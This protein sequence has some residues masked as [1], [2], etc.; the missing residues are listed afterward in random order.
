MLEAFGDSITENG[1]LPSGMEIKR[2]IETTPV[3][4]LRSRTVPQIRTWLHT[5]KKIQ[6]RKSSSV[7]KA[8]RNRVPTFIYSL[9]S[10]N[11]KNKVVPQLH[12]ILKAYEKSPSIQQYS[13]KELEEMVEKA[14]KLDGLSS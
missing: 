12:D 1:Q 11:I 9:F 10:Q 8:Q 5:Q 6:Q 14:I 7:E 2:L 4:S 3:S 13:V